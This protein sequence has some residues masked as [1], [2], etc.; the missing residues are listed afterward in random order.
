[1]K[2]RFERFIGYLVYT[3]FVG[4]VIYWGF[5]YEQ[6]LK[7]QAG[8][9][10]APYPYYT[11]MA[12]YPIFIG[13]ILAVPRLIQRIRQEGKWRIDWQMLLPVGI[14]TFLYNISMLLS[15]LLHAPLLFKYNWYQIM[16]SNPRSLDISGIVCGYIILASWLRISANEEEIILH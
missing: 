7:T 9:T 12:L 5:M 11:F 4:V 15:F 10:F 1:M 6:Y 14:P 3:L 2:K 8:R 13:M 16:L